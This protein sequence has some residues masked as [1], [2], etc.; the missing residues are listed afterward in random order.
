VELVADRFVVDDGGV[1][2]DLSSGDRVDLIMSTAGGV[3]EQARWASRCD[4]FADLH[5]RWIARLVDYGRIGEVRRFE[6]WGTDGAWHG[7]PQERER[8]IG[9][10]R[11][12]FSATGWS[13]GTLNDGQVRRVDGRPVVVPDATAG[14]EV[15]R[16]MLQARS[17]LRA[18]SVL[19]VTT[20]ARES[21]AAIAEM[22][23]DDSGGSRPRAVALSGPA[24]SGLD[25]ATAALSRAARVRGYIPLS[26]RVIS[27]FAP[28][29][30]GRTV[31][32]MAGAD[33]DAEWRAF[34]HLSLLSPKPH[35][36]VFAT[37]RDV[38]GVCTVPLTRVA[39]DALCQSIQPVDLPAPIAARV[40]TAATRSGGMPGRFAGLLWGTQ[41]M[42]PPI[43][44][45]TASRAAE[46]AIQ[47]GPEPAVV[48]N[49][50][51][52]VPASGWPAP[53]ELAALR[54][55][56]DAA[57]VFVRTGRHVS[58]ERLLR[59]IGASLARRHDWDH[60]V[61][62]ALALAESLIK[63]GRPRDAQSVLADARQSAAHGS[64]NDTIGKIAVLSG[65]AFTDD[66]CL[67]EAEAVLTSAVSAANGLQ[68]GAGLRAATLA[69][70]RCL[71]WRGRFD[72]AE[73]RL[74]AVEWDA[75]SDVEAVHLGTL[76][77]RLAGGR[78]D[79]SQ[80][81]TFAATA[82]ERAHKITRP[83]LI[84]AAA[85]A[86]ALSRLV[87]GDH[88]GV[89][90]AVGLSVKAARRAHD[91]L[92]SLRAHLLLA[93]SERREGRLATATKLCGRIGRMTSRQLPAIVRARTDLLA[94]LL[95]D[96]S[97]RDVASRRAQATGFHALKLFA[98]G[99]NGA[100]AVAAAAANDIVD[101]LHCCQTADEDASVLTNLCTRLRGRLQAV[102]IAFFIEERGAFVPVASD[103]GRVG[104]DLAAR[105]A[106]LGQAMAPH[107][108]DARIEGGAPVC[109]GGRLLGAVVVR[110]TLASPYDPKVAT[111]LL[112]TA[113]AAA[114]PALAE[115]SARRVAALSPRQSEL[116]GTSA[117]MADVRRAIDRAA[118]APFAVLVEGESGSGKELV[119]RALHRQGPRRDRPFCT[120]NCA[121]LPDD[122]VESELFGHSRGA[123]TGAISERPGVFEEAHTGTLFLDE[124][125][126]LSLRAQAKVL[127][128][129]QEGEL[130]RVGENI[131]RRV[132]V[133]LVAATN[134]DLRQEVATGRFRV[135]LLYRLDVIR[136]VL[137]PL[138]DRR[139]DI[140]LLAEHFWREATARIGSRAT[141]G[142][143]TLAQLARYDWPGNVRELQNVLAALA[144]RSSRR[145]VV[146]PAALPPHFHG[147]GA[148]RS[149]RLDSARRTFET[150]FIRAALART[151]GHRSRAAEELGVTR[152]G[153]TKLM[154]RL[155][156]STESEDVHP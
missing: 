144:V 92:L 141:L 50:D 104:P 95:T 83:E 62:A 120:L 65:V 45:T 48:V 137:P 4:R 85:Y 94:D 77:S 153:L 126:E 34:L 107:C 21:V 14:F 36:V 99:R 133:R 138:R 91:P 81:V 43:D 124:I 149:W 15:E 128:T 52:T 22:F 87:V 113:A 84:A 66:G 60:A 121:A 123:F 19:G 146:P 61:R 1:A 151:G 54:K 71:F 25:V 140:A 88:P 24:G 6:A 68:D 30:V 37:G 86:S 35:I 57:V 5:H 114:A 12:F 47:Y 40:A 11:E 58:G 108:V 89:A 38:R 17:R 13:P 136:L 152:Q 10:A 2:I 39:V 33:V 103:G 96:S 97:G 154:A 127:R 129:I 16:P 9:Y 105:I 109:Y 78:D 118:A 134:R 82:L 125:G 64:Q 56:L 115:L 145:G 51:S 131:A 3:S 46:Q 150:Q 49:L 111:V 116:L 110:W 98:P 70:G 69:L 135:D 132:D 102:G 142:L 122:L 20:I 72:A 155:G 130:R 41:H 73:Q 74:A 7:S 8:A 101:I 147:A 67:D 44:R 59:Q 156:L 27:A 117:A 29:L 79:L 23:L 80:A 75:E 28:L 26:A 100:A 143:A 53:G 31:V 76:K 139:D 63:R 106:A 112:T 42:R 55:R 90:T 18:G 93:E 119:A 148:E 32:L